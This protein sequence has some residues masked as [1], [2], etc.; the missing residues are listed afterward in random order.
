VFL[1]QRELDVDSGEQCENVGLKNSDQDFECGEDEAKSEGSDSEET[2]PVSTSEGGGEEDEV[3]CR[4][5][6]HQKEV[7]GDH[8]HEQSKR[9]RD[10]TQD[11]DREELDRRHDDVDR[12]GNA[13]REQRRLEEGARVLLQTGVDESYVGDDGQHEGETNNGATGNVH[14]GNDAR[15]VEGQHREEH[16]RQE[17]QKAL[18]VFLAQQVVGNIDSN[19]VEGHLCQAL[20]L[21]RDE[22][23]VA[24]AQ[25]KQE[26]EE[27]GEDEPNDDDSV[28]LEDRPG[29]E[30]RGWEELINGWPVEAAALSGRG[31]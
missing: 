18:A 30:D 12:P 24:R 10:G 25:P 20:T 7:A 4:K 16:C 6:Q 5:T 2:S 9:Q 26:H 14:T 15:Q 29:E 19:D 17:R 21:G 28:D 1:S 31:D 27:R 13:G 11:E 23:H 22:A 3:C 8:V